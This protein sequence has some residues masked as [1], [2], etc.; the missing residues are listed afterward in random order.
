MTVWLAQLRKL[1][2]K[3][4]IAYA[5]ELYYVSFFFC[6]Q[7]HIH[8]SQWRVM[9]SGFPPYVVSIPYIHASVSLYAF[10]P[11][12][13]LAAFYSHC[14]DVMEWHSQ[15]KRQ[16][17]APHETCM[18]SII[19]GHMKNESGHPCPHLEWQSCLESGAWEEKVVGSKKLQHSFFFF[20]VSLFFCLFTVCFSKGTPAACK[21]IE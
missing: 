6:F 16:D 7:V 18:L 13:S 15:C 19:H 11:F 17:W 14:A 21:L 4:A 1:A 8:S 10:L 20:F 5:S 3:L 2:A 12:I 9:C